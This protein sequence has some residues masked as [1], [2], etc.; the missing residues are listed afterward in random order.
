MALFAEFVLS[1]AAP[2][3][4]PADELPEIAL[5]GRSNVGKS[6]MINALMKQNKLARTSNT[7]GRTQTLN[8]YRIWPEG[9]PKLGDPKAPEDKTDRF[10]LKGSAR[11]AAHETGAFYLV[12]MPGYGYAKVSETQRRQWAK[13]IEK[14]L[15]ERPTLRAVIQIVDLRHPPSRD[16]VA[17]WDWLRHH[18]KIRLCLATKA[19]K[20]GKNQWPAH[21][22]EIVQGLGLRSI[23]TP[24]PETAVDS[25][26]EPI[27]IFSA[28]EGTGRDALWAWVNGVVRF[29]TKS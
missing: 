5:A 3:Q 1:A 8:Y 27:L 21:L 25:N 28:E 15:L 24:T 6:S 11:E 22:K 29:D 13:L 14:Y 4:F 9:K 19:D 18:G 20:V 23:V 16:D 2:N 17:M 26:A 7:P 10:T 12:D